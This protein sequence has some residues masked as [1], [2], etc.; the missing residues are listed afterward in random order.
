MSISKTELKARLAK[1]KAQLEKLEATYDELI[2]DG[3]ESY[4]F[5][6]GEGSQQAKKRKLSEIKD[7]IDELEAEIDNI[8]RRLSKTGLT[9]VTLRRKNRCF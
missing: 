1:K 7:Q 9:N 5:D 3:T 2:Q 8:Y 6:S 4:K